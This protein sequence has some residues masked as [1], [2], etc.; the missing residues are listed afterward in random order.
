MFTIWQVIGAAAF[1]VIGIGIGYSM[2]LHDFNT[3][4]NYIDP[5]GKRRI[6]RSGV[7]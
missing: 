7:G 1:V 6:R 2:C 5:N 3:G 4:K